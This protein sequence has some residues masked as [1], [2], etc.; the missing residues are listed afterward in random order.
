MPDEDEEA[1][2]ARETLARNVLAARQELGI[3]QA[4]LA[5]AA[6]LTQQKVSSIEAGHENI[7]LRT[8]A[9]LARALRVDRDRLLRETWKK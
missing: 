6:G 8:L 3:T 1:R 4:E 2:V 7:T 5:S 9:Q